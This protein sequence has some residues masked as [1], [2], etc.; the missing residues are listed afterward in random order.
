[1]TMPTL[2]MEDANKKKSL[3][4]SV[5]LHILILLIAL[6]PILKDDPEQSIDKQYAVAITFDPRG[7]SNSF[8]G[9]SS[10]GAQRR[11]NEKIDR[12]KTA[13]MDKVSNN[14]KTKPIKQ[15][16]IEIPTPQT[17]TAPAESDIFDQESEIEAAEQVVEVV[18]EVPRRKVESTSKPKKETSSEDVDT[19][20]EI[21]D[22]PSQVP[23][24]STSSANDSGN[25]SSSP[26]SKDGTGTGQ[27]E[28]G[29]GHGKDKS[30]NDSTSGIGTGGTGVGA[31]DGS[32]HGIFG[33]QPVDRP[34]LSSILISQNGRIVFK[35][36][37]DKRGKSTFVDVIKRGTTINDKKIIKAAYDYVGKFLWEEDNS[38]KNEQCGK[39][40]FIVDNQVD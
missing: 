1:M 21:E 29:T 15:P 17:P 27:G 32:G 2:Y 33:R 19:P 37:I 8:K 31:F 26:S 13:P 14:S 30:G 4:I 6:Y 7:S 40:T 5:G 25:N 10:E 35:V 23:A 28:K 22:V 12:V 20:E 16:K 36:C 11:R 3:R 18:N 34:K 9:V 38:I 24:S 39:Y